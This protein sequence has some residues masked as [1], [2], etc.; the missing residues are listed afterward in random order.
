MHNTHRPSWMQSPL[1]YS[2]RLTVWVLNQNQRFALTRREC[3]Y[4]KLSWSAD[5][6]TLWL[7]T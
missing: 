4:L 1:T 7:Q 6:V 3:L 5:T 2:L